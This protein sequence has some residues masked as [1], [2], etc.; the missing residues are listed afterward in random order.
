MAVQGWR[1]V[2]LLSKM[3]GRRRRQATAVAKGECGFRSTGFRQGVLGDY[4]AAELTG[5]QP[6]SWKNSVLQRLSVGR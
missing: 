3:K 2:A 6:K 5:V 1:H 4:S